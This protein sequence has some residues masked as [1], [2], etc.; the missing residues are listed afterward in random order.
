MRVLCTTFTAAVF[1]YAEGYGGHPEYKTSETF[2]WYNIPIWGWI[3]IALPIMGV[4]AICVALAAW[5]IIAKLTRYESNDNSFRQNES[6]SSSRNKKV[7][8]PL[9]VKRVNERSWRN[10]RHR[11]KCA[12]KYE[13]KITNDW[14]VLDPAV[15]CPICSKSL[16]KMSA[17]RLFRCSLCPSDS[18]QIGCFLCDF[19]LCQACVNHQR[20][21]QLIEV[22]DVHQSVDNESHQNFAATSNV[23]RRSF[24]PPK[25]LP[26]EFEPS[27]PAYEAVVD[28]TLD[29]EYLPSY[30]EAVKNDAASAN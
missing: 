10:G 18:I 30:E 15:T 26:Y 9:C 27:A 5:K 11:T 7:L 14:P 13:A 17:S 29:M 12:R 2:T 16:R 28:Q 21:Q 1:G 6:N 20:A 24:V 19:N 8:C 23:N 3:L 4:V 25:A 22:V